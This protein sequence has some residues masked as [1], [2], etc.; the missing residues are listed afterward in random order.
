MI[1]CTDCLLISI[2]RHKKYGDMLMECDPLYKY[3][4]RGGVNKTKN[5]Q[6]GFRYDYFDKE[7]IKV[8]NIIKSTTWR[9]GTFGQ[10]RPDAEVRITHSYGSDFH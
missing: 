10:K 8:Y 1:P 6:V 7:I 9:P 3:L 4:Y 2:C 5:M